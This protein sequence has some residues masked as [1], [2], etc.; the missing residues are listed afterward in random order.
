V[1]LTELMVAVAV[2]SIGALGF[3]G[4]F[5]AISR[6]LHISRGQTLATNLAQ[7]K[8]ESLKNLSYY[9]LLIT[10]AASTDPAGMAYDTSNYSPEQVS[11]GGMNFTRYTYVAMAELSNNKVTALSYTYPDTGMKEIIVDIV[12]EDAGNVIRHF[13]LSNLDENPNVNPLD[14]SLSGYVDDASTS[15]GLAGAIV[16]LEENPALTGQR[17]TIRSAFITVPTRWRRLPLGIR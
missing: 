17:G 1:T 5:S 11:I 4:A 7:E 6:S 16:R 8:I 3:I 13:S 9:D 15:L 2:L 12:W 10:T 14:S